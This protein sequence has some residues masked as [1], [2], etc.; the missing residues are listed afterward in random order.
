[1]GR[2]TGSVTA[3]KVEKL[4]NLASYINLET[5]WFTMTLIIAVAIR[6]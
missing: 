5:Q 1:M 4:L 6:F 2:R 3:R